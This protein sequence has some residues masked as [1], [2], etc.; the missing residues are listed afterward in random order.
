VT[1]SSA[2]TPPGTDESSSA[3]TALLFPGQGSQRVGMGRRL[4]SEHPAARATFDEA[5]DALDL[6]LSRLCFDGPEADLTL[7]EFCQPAILAV[8]VALTEGEILQARF[9]RNPAVTPAD[10]L[11]IIDRKTAS[12]FAT[13][14]RTAAHLAGAPGAVVEAMRASGAHVGRAFQ[15]QDDLLDVEGSP[16]RT[17]K[18]R[19]LDLRDGNP[20]LPIVLALECD[21]EVRRIFGLATPTPA[22]VEAGLA[23]I[24]RTGVC[25][26][27]GARAAAELAT[28]LAGIASLPPSE[29]RAA[30]DVL[31]QGLGDRAV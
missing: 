17:G 2:A 8:C 16:A 25:R 15:M 6:P 24:R 3:A 1:S 14:A 10:Y 9:R 30:L 13:G 23:R 29:A 26:T 7:T 21:P 20:S 12:L 5:D 31:A 27:V 4:A 18:P 28:A 11:E 22:D 19:G